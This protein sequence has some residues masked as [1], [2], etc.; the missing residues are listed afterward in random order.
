MRPLLIGLILVGSAVGGSMYER[1]REQ[2]ADKDAELTTLRT[3]LAGAQTDLRNCR[4][5]QKYQ[6]LIPHR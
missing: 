5:E 3:S 6:P 1:L 2:L 4:L